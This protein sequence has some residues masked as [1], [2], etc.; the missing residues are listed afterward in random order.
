MNQQDRQLLLELNQETAPG[1]EQL[2]G[3]LPILEQLEE[4][5]S[6]DARRSAWLTSNI[7]QQP[8]ILAQLTN[9]SASTTTSGL[10][11]I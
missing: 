4:L 6:L 11:S 7:F 2:L 10:P 3:H 5:A 8:E 9:T 1:K